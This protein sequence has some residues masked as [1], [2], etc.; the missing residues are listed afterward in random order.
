MKRKFFTAWALYEKPVNLVL[1]LL[2]LIYP[3]IFNSAYL[4]NIGVMIGIYAILA[5]SLN[6]ISG[7][8]GVV[9]LG[10]AAFFGIGAYTGALLARNCGWN[11]L[12]TFLAAAVVSALFGLLLGIPTLRLSGKYLGIVTLSFCEIMRI[13]ENNLKGLTRGPL[14]L[15]GIPRPSI[16]GFQFD[17][18][19]KM[20]YLVVALGALTVFLITNLMNSRIGRGITAVKDDEVAASAMGIKIFPYK[21]IAFSVSAMLA[22]VAGAFYA[23]YIGFIDPSSFSFDQSTQILSMTI[24]GGLCNVFGSIFGAAALIALPEILRP[25]MEWR[26]VIYGGLLVVMMIWRPNG[27][28]GGINLRH[29]RQQELFERELAKRA[30]DTRGMPDCAVKEEQK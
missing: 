13:L 28:F 22:G 8:M 24:M 4:I 15:P 27:L 29:I 21:L 26:Q 17:S 14:G 3:L 7:Y 10:H 25:I 5:M 20:Y 18:N 23:H 6:I 30:A 9:T 16:F 11:F 12:F 2:V 1:L 19:I